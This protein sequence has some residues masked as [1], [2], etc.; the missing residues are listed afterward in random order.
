VVLVLLLACC[1]VIFNIFAARGAV[2]LSDPRFSLVLSRGAVPLGGSV[3]IH[4]RVAGRHDRIKRFTLHLEAWEEASYR[5]DDST[6]TDNRLLMMIPIHET[7]RADQTVGG[8]CALQVPPDAMHSFRA[9]HNM[10]RWILVA[11]G[12]IPNGRDVKNGFEITILPRPIAFPV[13]PMQAV[14]AKATA[15]GPTF[16]I[17]IAV[18]GGRTAFAPGETIAGT[19]AWRR[20]AQPAKVVVRLFWFTRGRGTPDM[21]V[22][23][24]ATV[25]D[26]QC[27]GEGAIFPARAK[28]PL[29]F[30]RGPDRNR[31]GA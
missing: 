22:V 28:R 18:A 23:E 8:S 26:T 6:R 15:S 21:Q 9:P 17:R 24:Q 14:A 20:N 10:I 3:E 1:G 5:R 19:V 16:D 30:L 25:P 7:D 2:S 31:L 27:L 12:Q 29:Q 4:W 13:S 11:K